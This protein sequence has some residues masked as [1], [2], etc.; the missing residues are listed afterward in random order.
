MMPQR[1]PRLADLVL[2]VV[3]TRLSGRA[4]PA[5]R[6][7][8][9]TEHRWQSSGRGAIAHAGQVAREQAP[10]AG[11]VFSW[12]RAQLITAVFAR[13]LADMRNSVSDEPF[14][15]RT[16]SRPPRATDAPGRLKRPSATLWRNQWR[17][18]T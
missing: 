9:G 3:G 7:C 8:V 14:F 17:R 5:S 11:E 15:S 2:M 18:P 16:G 10:A 12:T 4:E 6:R 13:C 1:R